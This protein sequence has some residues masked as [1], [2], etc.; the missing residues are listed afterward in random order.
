L[1]EDREEVFPD[2]HREEQGM[3]EL[4]KLNPQ[5]EVVRRGK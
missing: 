3:T 1:D 2:L 5:R 4:V